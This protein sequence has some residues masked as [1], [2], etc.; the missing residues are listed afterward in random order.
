MCFRSWMSRAVF[1]SMLPASLAQAAEADRAP[2]VAGFP[3]LR[4]TEG[5]V[6]AGRL[7]LGELSCHACHPVHE[8]ADP[9]T[10]GSGPLYRKQAPVLDHVGSR[11]KPEYLRAYLKA[12]HAVRPG[13]T[14]PDVLAGMPEA[15]RNEAVEAL[16]HFLAST[17]TPRQVPLDR[18]AV[19]RGRA[20]YHRVGCAACHGGE[21]RQSRTPRVDP[22]DEF[23]EESVAARGT[24]PQIVPLGD[25]A[26]KYTE[27]GLSRF[28]LDPLQV[29]PSGRMPSLN[30][31]RQEAEAIAN[32]L[33]ADLR[34]DLPKN[35]DFA[36]YE[37]DWEELPDFSKLRPVKSGRAS[38][39][40]VTEGRR[41]DQF[42]VRFETQLDLPSSGN[43]RFEL[44]SDDVSA[45]EI[46]GQRLVLNDGI[47]PAQ[48]VSAAT[49]L[50]KGPHRVVVTCFKGAGEGELSVSVQGPRLPKQDL[51]DLVHR[52]G[53]E[54]VRREVAESP[55]FRVDPALRDRGRSLFGSLGCASCHQ[56]RSEQGLVASSLSATAFEKA[57]PMRGCL[58]E[59]P[60]PR[61]PHY[62]L[63]PEQREALTVVLK[64]RNGPRT[65]AGPRAVLVH[66]LAA[67]DCVACH[68]RGN[69]GGVSDLTNP[70]FETT[71]AEM[72]DEGRIPPPL[73]GVGAKLKPE[74]LGHILRDGS[75]DRP[76]MLTRMPKF[77][78][79][80]VGYLKHLLALLDHV[81]PA[82]KPEFS[83]SLRRVK[84]DG[85]AIV[86][87][88]GFNCVGCHTFRGIESTGVQGTDMTLMA[89]R[90][91]RDWYCHYVNDP[92]K[93]RPGTR[94]PSA[95]PDGQSTLPG[96]L[97][98][99]A[100]RQVEA[101]WIYLS[102]GQNAAVPLG[103]GRDPIPLAPKDGEAVLY[104]N[105]IEGAGPSAIGVGYPEGANLAFDANNFRV[106]M[107]WQGGFIDAA[108]HWTGRGAG[109]QSPMGRNVL[110]L[111]EGPSLANLASR[112]ESWPDTPPRSLNYHFRGYRLTPDRRPTFLYD[113]GPIHVKERPEALKNEGRA[114]FE[115]VFSVS[116]DEPTETLFLRASVADSV[117][118]KGDG[119]YRINNDWT[120]RIEGGDE[121]FVRESKGKKE[122]VVP[123]PL[124][125]H[126]VEVRQT[127]EW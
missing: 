9:L 87:N 25:L 26:A 82:P 113:L 109:S 106:A 115:L 14:M 21:K 35:V 99:H 83:K 122:L 43:Y 126:P 40:D 50:A 58:A 51:A 45:L 37:G 91:R 16:T 44:V 67:F 70:Y 34:A 64:D 104:R 123:V 111:P 47:Q 7:L 33:L 31:N 93:F 125:G 95:W 107:V 24:P 89:R 57:D 55:P 39:F 65:P 13:S 66:T 114:T 56:M 6:V 118:P 71:Q 101:V 1:L 74:W 52:V 120:T 3:V 72:G 20:L 98:G 32:Y 38:G 48:P 103:L 41:T 92:Q 117:E 46:D 81:D 54:P 30:L 88:Q 2:V 94:M 97:D 86:G 17:G 73:D 100:A 60:G 59:T 42:A 8:G 84:E 121:P 77:G 27:P 28:L 12:P 110:H 18:R 62:E 63:S 4:K 61:V 36:Y 22:E 19:V 76:Y 11:V 124:R 96:V 116:S 23:P 102:D 112:D 49:D 85:R 5:P 75:K 119:R 108:Q 79:S 127:V 90:L 29:R 15:Q 80:N 105:F 69:M 78:G 53:E 10:S 68:R